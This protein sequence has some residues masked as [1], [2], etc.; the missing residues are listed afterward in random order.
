M[1][2]ISNDNNNNNKKKEYKKICKTCGKEFITNR[3]TTLYCKECSENRFKCKICGKRTKT[4][5]STCSNKCRQELMKR[6]CN[7]KYGCDYPA[8]NKEINSKT[9]KTKLD[10]YGYSTN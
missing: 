6:T 3:H 9:M 7:E 4:A 2:L 1:I 10:K 5:N 8:Q